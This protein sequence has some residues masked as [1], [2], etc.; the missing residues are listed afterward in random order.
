M[1]AR[2]WHGRVPAAKADEYLDYLER[3]GLS[4]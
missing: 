1:I 2:Q 3:T 4:D